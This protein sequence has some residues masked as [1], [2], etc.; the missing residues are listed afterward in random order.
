MTHIRT[1]I[2]S[3]VVDVLDNV[4]PLSGRVH[5]TR[6][7]PFA[8]A[9]LPRVCVYTMDETSVADGTGRALLRQVTVV[10]DI[11]VKGNDSIDNAVDDIAVKVEAAMAADRSRGGLAFDTLLTSTRLSVNKEGEEKTGHGVLT[12]V[13]TYRTSRSNSEVS[14]P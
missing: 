13:V 11:I 5:A 1:G 14:N 6:L 7:R 8:Q 12:Y 2:R 3:N 10:V 4:R 9:E